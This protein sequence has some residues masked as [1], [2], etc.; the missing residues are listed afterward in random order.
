MHIEGVAFD[1]KEEKVKIKDG[2]EI[3]MQECKV[4]DNTAII[5]LTIFGD[6]T[7]EVNENSFYKISHLRVAKYDYEWYLKTTESSTVIICLDLNIELTDLDKK[8][9]E[10]I[11][12]NVKLTIQVT[13]G[14]FKSLNSR[15]SWPNCNEDITSD[16]EFIICKKCDTMSLTS[17]CKTDTTVKFTD[18]IG[19]D[20]VLLRVDRLILI[21]HSRLTAKLELA[22]TILGEKLEVFCDAS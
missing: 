3:R 11:S 7:D 16:E 18:Q 22:K 20:K 21:E 8:E 1:L 10:S 4:K 12:T 13:S 14:Y 15:L 6:L 2:R 17:N 9:V 5:K 19:N